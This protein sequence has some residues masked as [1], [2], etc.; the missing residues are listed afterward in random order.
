MLS[1][2]LKKLKTLESRIAR[3]RA[4]YQDCLKELQ[5]TCPHNLIAECPYK[6]AGL[7]MDAQ[8]PSRICEVCGFEE[9]G[10]GYGYKVL[11]GDRFRQ[12]SRDDLSK[13]RRRYYV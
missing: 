3:E 5:K 9:E 4:K 7:I 11:T 6:P 2:L 10:W 8:P 1:K 13:F 12:V